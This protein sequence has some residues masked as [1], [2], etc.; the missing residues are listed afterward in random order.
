[1][2]QFGWDNV[3]KT[4]GENESRRTQDDLG[5]GSTFYANGGLRGAGGKRAGLDPGSGF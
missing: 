2:A 4:W 3:S 5:T 1:M